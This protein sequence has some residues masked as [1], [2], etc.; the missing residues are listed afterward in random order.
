MARIVAVSACST[1]KS[2]ASAYLDYQSRHSAEILE[3]YYTHQL[4]NAVKGGDAGANNNKMLT[5][6]RNHVRDCFDKT[7]EDAVANKY[8]AEVGG[9]AATASKWHEILGNKHGFIYDS[10]A[11]DYTA[12]REQKQKNLDQVIADWNSRT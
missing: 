11:A 12:W 6:I 2:Q 8:E 9:N 10:F 1:E 3:E 4:A 5:Y 7:F